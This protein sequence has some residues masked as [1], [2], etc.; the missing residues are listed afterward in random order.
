MI[1]KASEEWRMQCEARHVLT[2]Q[3][4]QAYYLLVQEKRGKE[5]ANALIEA[6]NEQR[7]LT[8]G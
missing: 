2:L 5:A 6:V 8:R 4:R 1:D 3:N 7:K